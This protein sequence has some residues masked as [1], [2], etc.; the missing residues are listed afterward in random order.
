MF[1]RRLTGFAGICRGLGERLEL[2]LRVWS[3]AR[4]TGNVDARVALIDVRRLW[5]LAA[6]P[7]SVVDFSFGL[8]TSDGERIELLL[9]GAMCS[10]R[11]CCAARA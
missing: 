11:F 3:A 6:P 10:T 5:L 9:A 1:T 8:W 2:D 7:H 4:D